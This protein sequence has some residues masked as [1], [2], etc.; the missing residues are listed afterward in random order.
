MMKCIFFILL[1]AIMIIPGAVYGQTVPLDSGW[2]HVRNTGSRE[3]S[4][5]PEQAQLSTYRLQFPSE[6]LETESTLSLRQYDVKGSWRVLLNGEHLGILIQDEKDLIRYL[7]IPA[8][9]LK[10]QNTL[11][12]V[13]SDNQADDIRIGEITWHMRPLSRVLSQA[14]VD[15]EVI[16]EGTNERTPCRITIVDD[17]GVLQQASPADHGTLA[18]RSGHVYTGNGKATLGLAPGHYT[19]FVTRGFEYGVDSVNAVLTAGDHFQ[20]TFTLPRQV[21]TAGW[22]SSDTHIHTLTFSG[23][24]DASAADRVLTIAGEGIELPIITDH[25]VRVDLRPFAIDQQVDRYFTMITGNELTTRVGHFNIFPAGESLA[26]HRVTNWETL[27]RNLGNTQARA[28]I[29]NHA[30]DI[31]LGFRPFDPAL[32]IASAGVRLDGWKFPFNAMEVINSGSQQTDQMQLTRDWFGMLNGGHIVTPAGSSDSHDVSRFIVGQARTYIRSNDEDVSAINVREAVRNFV[33]GNVMVSFGLLTEIEIND[34]Y[35][36]GELVPASDEVKIAVKVS[37]PSWAWADKVA[38]YANGKKIREAAI[39]GRDTAGLKWNGTWHL[40]LPPHDLFL[41]AV[42]EGPGRDLPFWP[43]ARPYQPVS[44]DWKPR[45]FG[46]SGAVWLDGD[47]N[48]KRDPASRYAE[49]LWQQANGDV[50]TLVHELASFD[51]SIAIQAAALLHQ[52]KRNL[53]GPEVTRALRTASPATKAG[54]ETV[55]AETTHQ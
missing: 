1:T 3:W 27:S 50:A 25:N 2:Y 49:K 13:S 5:F 38:L 40:T 47:K 34:S 52:N 30:R 18:I 16:D 29:L 23:H 48:Q 39:E 7:R 35:G 31:H 45:I 11:E 21:S 9:A 24:G 8:R 17:R 44:P 28:I 42:A 55:I 33:D 15:F 36:P 20:H 46:L 22:V 26:D 6:A 14:H 41:V 53:R 32:H 37:G 10:T 12:I 4:D 51:E 54:F 19:F 43:I